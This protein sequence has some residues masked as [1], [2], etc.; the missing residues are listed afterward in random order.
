[1]D[2]VSTKSFRVIVDGVEVGLSSNITITDIPC[3]QSVSA[4]G[5]IYWQTAER[6]LE[7]DLD[8]KFGEVKR[9]GRPDWDEYFL[10][11]ASAVAARGD[12]VSR[13]IGAV[14]VDKARRIVSTGY[15]GVPP[16]AV[17]C[18]QSP[19][20]RAR[21]STKC[22]G[23]SD[24]N[25]T[26]AEANALLYAGVAGAKKATLYISDKPCDMCLKLIKAA[27]IKRVVWYDFLLKGPKEMTL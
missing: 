18:L 21:A 8:Y 10:G 23:Y 3:S 16:K 25:S 13:Q 27:R 24:C 17:G 20:P 15:N 26:H 7:I 9:V 11:I 6:T 22:P 5:Q 12:C 4:V 14:I 1:M 19:C 2:S